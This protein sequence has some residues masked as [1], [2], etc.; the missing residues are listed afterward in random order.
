VE[1]VPALTS[2]SFASPLAESYDIS[3]WLCEKQPELI[4]EEHRERIQSLLEKLYSFHAKTL[5]IGPNEKKHGIPNK[6]AE[7]LEQKDLT[8]AHRR[9][10]EIK[11][12]L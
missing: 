7:L 11:S 12:V 9:A 8:E 4:P 6:A 10:L 5:T 1:Q 3:K 2:A